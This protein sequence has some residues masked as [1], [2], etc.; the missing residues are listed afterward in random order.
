MEI[1]AN[2]YIITENQELMEK[3]EGILS[4]ETDAIFIWNTIE[5]DAILPLSRAWYVCDA[6]TGMTTDPSGW[7]DCL[8]EC[9]NL[10]K[11][12][13]AVIIQFWSPDH[14]EDYLEYANTTAHGDVEIGS[15]CAL[16]SFKQALGV[17]DIRLVYQELVSGRS[18]HERAAL[19]K[20]RQQHEAKRKAK[21][22]FEVVNGILKKYW[23]IGVAEEIPSGITAI[24]EFAFVDQRGWERMLLEDEEYEA[25]PLEY[26]TIPNSVQRIETYA[27]AYCRNLKEL[28]IPDNVNSIGDR[29]FEGCEALES[30]KLPEGLKELGEFAFFLCDKL[31]SIS[32]PA[33]IKRIEPGTFFGCS[34]L[35]HIDIPCTVVSIEKEAFMNCDSLKRIAIP[36]SVV[37]IKESAFAGCS[38]LERVIIPKSI[39]YV[40]PNAFKGCKKLQEGMTSGG[41]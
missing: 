1:N 9:A 31:K 15:R 10:L 32:I 12:H 2:I 40:A 20:R 5:P 18:P 28:S 30:V 13:G 7:E 36:E 41:S 39:E 34:L 27:L 25:P 11:K 24:G 16:Y 37:E 6:N 19:A 3:T 33:G 38:S 29:A 14:P 21:G 26:L 4:H 35:K 22:D 17:D 23:G 8:Y